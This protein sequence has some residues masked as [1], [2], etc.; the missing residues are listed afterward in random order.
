MKKE[1]EKLFKQRFD[2]EKKEEGEE[3]ARVGVETNGAAW[4]TS[5]ELPRETLL[6]FL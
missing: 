2:K 5:K 6:S 1:A 3:E 4:G